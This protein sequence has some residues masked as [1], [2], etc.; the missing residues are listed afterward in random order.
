MVCGTISE[1]PPF[2]DA[3]SWFRVVPKNHLA[4]APLFLKNTI[5]GPSRIG[6][7]MSIFLD[8]T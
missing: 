8:W 7:K 1:S 5:P 6:K 3:E 4:D 2:V